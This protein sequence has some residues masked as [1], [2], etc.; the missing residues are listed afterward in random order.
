MGEQFSPLPRL[1]VFMHQV[2]PNGLIV[3]TCLVCRKVFASSTLAGLRLA[4]AVHKCR[5]LHHDS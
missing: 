5:G 1:P 2:I 3:S 4:E